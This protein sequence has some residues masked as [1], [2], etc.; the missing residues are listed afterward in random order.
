MDYLHRYV[1]YILVSSLHALIL[2]RQRMLRRMLG[3]QKNKRTKVLFPG[4]TR[5][6]AE[7]DTEGLIKFLLNYGFYKFGYE[8]CL[9]LITFTI[10]Y[11]DDII[12]IAYCIWLILL[13]AL[14][15]PQIV[16]IWQTL[17]IFTVCSIIIQF[18]ILVFFPRYFCVGKRK[19][20]G[21][22]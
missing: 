5:E 3:E 1:I 20:N 7:E 22:Q 16:K 14:K 18:L 19:I 12:A 9:I 8:I 4:V 6:S 13:L 10:A 11:R 21:N 15:R 2:M 17:R